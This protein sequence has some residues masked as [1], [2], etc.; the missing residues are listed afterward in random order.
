MN[1]RKTIAILYGGKTSEHAV[2]KISAASVVRNFDQERYTLI[3]IGIDENGSWHLQDK[4][5][6][7]LVLQGAELDI[8]PGKA[9]YGLAGRGLM[10]AEGHL[11]V[12]IVFPVLHG[13]NGEDGTIQG[14][15]ETLELAYTGAGILASA[16]G[17]DKIRAKKIWQEEGLPVVPFLTFTDEE[18]AATK[19]LTTGE[20]SGRD[21]DPTALFENWSSQLGLPFF[22]KP[23]RGGSSVGIN[24]IKSKKQLIPAI[25][26]AL[27]LDSHILIEQAIDAREIECAILG[28]TDLHI[29]PAGE[30]I[31]HHEFYDYS[32]KYLDPAGAGFD[33]PAQLP[34]PVRELVEGY[35]LTAYRALGG[36]GL[37]RV[38]FFLDKKDGAVY[39]NEMNTL[40]GLTP[41]S[42][43]PKMCIAGGMSFS[44]LLETLVELGL[45]RHR[46]K[47][48]L[49]LQYGR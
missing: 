18:Y 38:D 44:R 2:S 17:M 41:I 45:E 46:Q 28:N 29:F 1:S 16:L 32:G 12:D 27:A 15:L 13:T 40:P 47:S 49:D 34:D 8:V 36:E 14:F 3:L 48:L 9:V 24:K 39:L 25:E 10:T 20:D 30:V 21:S 19:N 22:I 6:L 26:E 37:A 7:Q 43:Y 5:L 11:Q 35:A 4:N 23:C 42:M 31:S 33:I